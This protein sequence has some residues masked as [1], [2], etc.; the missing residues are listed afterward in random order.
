MIDSSV[1]RRYAKALFDIATEK[2]QT[3][4]YQ[5]ELK[6]LTDALATDA[7]FNSLLLGRV[8]S[9]AEK[10]DL[11]RK[12]F[13]KVFSTDVTSFVCLVLD[14]GREALLP[15]MFAA[16]TELLDAAAGV[17]PV[18][19]TAAFELSAAQLDSLSKAFEKK[20][21]SPVRLVTTVDKSLIGGLKAQ[22]GDT[23][24]DGS[25]SGRINDLGRRLCK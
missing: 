15:E 11:V 16:Y 18:N 23:V 12:V 2:D 19:V 14:K 21:E 6:A 7:D 3:T 24:Y 20:L 13:G 25:L 8:I 5:S 22:V 10:K 17:I 4:N 9:A 1:A